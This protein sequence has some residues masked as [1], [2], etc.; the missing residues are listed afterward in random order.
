[1]SL[2]SFE[3]GR[4]VGSSDSAKHAAGGL[5]PLPIGSVIASLSVTCLPSALC[6]PLW[7]SVPS[8]VEQNCRLSNA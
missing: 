6:G 5:L 7:F 1:M 4:S 2:T 3:I 8:V